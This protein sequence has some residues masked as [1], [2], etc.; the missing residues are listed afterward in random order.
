M[1]KLYPL[2]ITLLFISNAC[3]Q[4]TGNNDNSPKEKE[5]V[6]DLIVLQ[7]AVDIFIKD[8]DLHNANISFYAVDVATG[9]V[10]AEHNSEKCIIPASAQKVISTATALEIL[11]PSHRFTTTLE[12]SGKIDATTKTLKGNIYIKGGGDPT[13]GSHRMKGNTFLQDWTQAISKLGISKIEGQ[14]IGDASVFSSEMTPPTWTWEDL[15]NY[16]G[17]GAC[18]LSIFENRY[19]IFF[20][21][22]TYDGADTKVLKIDPYIPNLEI[23]NEV[24]A[25]N[26]N[27]DNAFIFG[28][29]YSY[30]RIIRGTIPKNKSNF[31][32]KGSFPDPAL[33]AAITLQNELEKKSIKVTM[34]A[35]TVRQ[36]KLANQKDENTRVFITKSS[37]P[38]L[39]EIIKLTNM[40][41]INLYAEHLLNH[42]G[43]AKQ[44]EGSSSAGIKTIEHFWS[45][46]G[47]DINGLNL[48]DGSGLSHYNTFTAK[49]A[50]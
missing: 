43:L 40:H 36:M 25:S 8:K 9:K 34:P 27:S 26:K 41:S 12:Y 4:T 39:S 15:G 14:I 16:Y 28:A 11:G 22:G 24:K 38:A 17:A 21:S 49:Q 30:L 3:G 13:L 19:K 1:K 5:D 23:I 50:L 7:K 44:K 32:I 18:G 47:M 46:K 45:E 31:A 48:N 33:M 42:I 29:P 35:T 6:K 2:L 37:S 10:L 20:K